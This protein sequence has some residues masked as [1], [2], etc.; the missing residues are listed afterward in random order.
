MNRIL[1]P[2]LFIPDGSTAE[3]AYARTTHLAIGAHQDDLEFMAY[4]AIAECHQKEVPSFFGIIVTDGVGSIRGDSAASYTAE[5]FATL[6]R[7]EQREAARIGKYSAVVQLGVSS[8]AVKTDPQGIA[9]ELWSYCR[10]LNPHEIF[11]HNPFDKHPTHVA[12]FD[13]S[14][15]ALRKKEAAQKPRRVLGCEVWRGLDWVPDN[16]KVVLDTSYDPQFAAR[17]HAVFASQIGPGKQYDHATAGRWLANATFFQPRAADICSRA[18]YAIDC[19]ALVVDP[20]SS[21]AQFMRNYITA[22]E[23]D[24]YSTWEG[25]RA[26]K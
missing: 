1:A 18:A 5:E 9:E 15:R 26:W 16:L 14:I 6:R 11:L 7:N 8:T 3:V 24:T 21:I 23:K 25:M 22:F 20:E 12:T 17:L 13:A 2:D 10:H 19:T 4:A